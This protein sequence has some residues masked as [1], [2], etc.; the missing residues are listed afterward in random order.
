M[1]GFP[2]TGSPEP[3][4]FIRAD[5]AWLPFHRSHH[6]CSL[7]RGHG[8]LQSASARSSF[9]FILIL[10]QICND[11]GTLFRGTH[12]PCSQTSK[13]HRG[14]F[15]GIRSRT[16]VYVLFLDQAAYAVQASVLRRIEQKV[17]TVPQIRGLLLWP[18]SHVRTRS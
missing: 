2:Q 7:G 17:F 18:M 9:V 3:T 4:G 13:T 8:C 14:V 12:F 10:R 6:R 1:L 11:V 15:A 16:R 5:K